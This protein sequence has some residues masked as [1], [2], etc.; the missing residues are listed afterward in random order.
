M[1]LTSAL[2]PPKGSW[3]IQDGV[4]TGQ[5][6]PVG[7]RLGAYL[8]TEE[9]FGDFELLIDVNPDWS[10]DSGIMIRATPIGGQGFQVHMDYRYRGSVGTFYGNG[11]GPFRAR[12]YAYQPKLDAKGNA[13][14][15]EP[16]ENP[17]G[18][19]RTEAPG[20]GGASRHV[21]QGLEIRATGT[22][23]TYA[24]WASIRVL[25][26]GSTAPRSPNSMQA[27]SRPSTMTVTLWQSCWDGKAT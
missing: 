27:H 23:C 8:I 19:G 24:A 4:I 17:E 26:P 3:V 13:I 20:V 25:R 18:R 7:S 14:G 15:L 9:V 22:P 12:Q 10:V 2:S 5:Q 6:D 16:A 21:F 11:L 1:T